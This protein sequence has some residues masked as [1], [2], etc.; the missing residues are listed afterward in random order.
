MTR[1]ADS[2]LTVADAGRELL[3]ELARVV[4]A[5]PEPD[6][7]AVP[8]LLD[9]V[10]A[11]LRRARGRVRR[12]ERPAERKVVP[13]PAQPVRLGVIR[14]A[15]IRVVIPPPRMFPP[16]ARPP[17]GPTA[18]A[19]GAPAPIL[20]A[21]A[22]IGGDTMTQPQQPHEQRWWNEPPPPPPPG[23]PAQ[24]TAASSRVPPILT[25]SAV[26][27]TVLALVVSSTARII[28]YQMVIMFGAVALLASIAGT[29]VSARHRQKGL[30]AI[31]IVAGLLAVVA[32]G[33]GFSAMSEYRQ[34]IE[35]LGR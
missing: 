34:I 27:L 4:Q 33:V 25:W 32:L 1:V 14:P 2:A 19:P 22:T 31:A 5:H 6:A 28:D 7:A 30:V 8:A 3:A 29:V 12:A 26:A 16:R 35:D 15:P 21:T 23:P 24:P 10:A 9:E 13:G 11:V 17:A 18:V 20:V